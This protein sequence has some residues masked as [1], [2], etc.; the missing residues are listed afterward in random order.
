MLLNCQDFLGLLSLDVKNWSLDRRPWDP[1]FMGT[2]WPLLQ[3]DMGTVCLP[4]YP[5]RKGRVPE[6]ARAVSQAASL[7]DTPV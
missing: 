1:S 6:G 3:V 5:Y 4:V 7:M 2:I